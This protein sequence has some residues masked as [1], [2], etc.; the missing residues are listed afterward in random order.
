MNINKPQEGKILLLMPSHCSIYKLLIINLER[1]GYEVSYRDIKYFKYENFNQRLYNFFRKTFLGDRNYKNYLRKKCI[2]D[3]IKDAFQ[4]K[5]NYFNYTLVIRPDEYTIGTIQHLKKISKR[6]IGYQWDGFSRFET[7][8]ELINTFDVFGVFDK[9]DYNNNITKHPNLILTHNFYFDFLPICNK[10]VDLFYIGAKEDN[11]IETLTH[12][13]KIIEDTKIA[14]NFR[15][16][17]KE[18]VDKDFIFPV[19]DEILSYQEML[20]ISSKAKAIIDIKHPVHNGLS[21]RFFEALY[22]SQK[23]ITDNKTAKEMDFY[24]PNNI[25][26]VEDFQKLTQ[27]ELEDFLNKEYV[28]IPKEIKQKYSFESWFNQMIGKK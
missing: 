23:V 9:I 6:V 18:D 17:S 4:V 25:L 24:H 15:L 7:P 16:F 5:D 10:E 12:L 28:E 20:I 21:L 11:R 1:M 26:V 8:S 19:V 13:V 27:T 14:Y 3:D 22:F 2:E